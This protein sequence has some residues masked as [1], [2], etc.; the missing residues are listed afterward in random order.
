[1]IVINTSSTSFAS[2]A[3][4]LISDLSGFGC[5]QT[6]SSTHAQVYVLIDLARLPSDLLLQTEIQQNTLFRQIR[7]HSLQTVPCMLMEFSRRRSW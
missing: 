6:F 7:E 3:L 1:M 5:Y 2:A 4:F